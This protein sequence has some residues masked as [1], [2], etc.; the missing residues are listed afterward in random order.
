MA[1]TKYSIVPSHQLMENHIS[2]AVLDSAYGF[3]A[4]LTPTGATVLLSIGIDAI[5][6]ASVEAADTQTG[7]A[8]TDIN[9]LLLAKYKPGTT[10]TAHSFAASGNVT[11]TGFA[12]LLAVTVTTTTSSHDEVWLLTG[13]PGVDPSRWLVDEG[14]ITFTKLAYDPVSSPPIQAI[15]ADTLRVTGLHLESGLEATDPTLALATV[16]DRGSPGELRCF[17]LHLAPGAKPVWNYYQQEQNVGTTNLQLVPGRISSDSESWGLYKLYTLGA[18]TSL[19]YLP[20]KGRFG[21]PNATLFTVPSGATTMA[22]LVHQPRSSG[23]ATS[24]TDLFVAADGFIGYFPYNQRRPHEAIKL[25]T[26]PLVMGVTQ[27]HAVKCKD[28]AVLWGLNGAKQVFYTTAPLAERANPSAW[29]APIPLLSK[30]TAITAL[31][32]TAPNSISLFAV[33][34]LAGTTATGNSGS[35]LIQLS[36]NPSTGAWINSVHPLP[37][38]TDC[39]TLKT[40]TTRVLL[41]DS[42]NVPQPGASISAALSADCSLIINGAVKNVSTGET[43]SLKTDSGGYV[44]IIHAVSSLAT[45]R[46]TLTLPDGSPSTI[47]PTTAK[48]VASGT[49]PDAV[50]GVVAGLQVISAKI[51]DLPTAAAA[52]HSLSFNPSSNPSVTPGDIFSDLGDLVQWIN[53]VVEDVGN[54]VFDVVGEAIH[55]VVTVAETVFKAIINTVE[56]ALHAITALFN[57]IKADI[58]AVF[59]WLAFLFDWKD[60]IAV[61]DALKGVVRQSFTSFAKLE[62]RVKESGDKWFAHVKDSIL[63]GLSS[64]DMAKP[65]ED[66]SLQVV[67]AKNQRKPKTDLRSDTR[68]GWLKDRINTPPSSS[69]TPAAA[70]S[71]PTN[72]AL[73]ADNADPT[74]ALL[75]QIKT[76]IQH[77]L[78]TL[79]TAFDNLSKV[80]KGEMTA[81]KFFQDLL[82]SVEVLGLEALKDVFDALMSALQAITSKVLEALDM[83]IDIPIL[84]ALYKAATG[85]PLTLLDVLCLIIS[86]GVNLVYKIVTGGGNPHHALSSVTSD[87]IDKAIGG[88]LGDTLSRPLPGGANLS[89]AEKAHE[90]PFSDALQLFTGALLILQTHTL[91]VEGGAE[92]V[93]AFSVADMAFTADLAIRTLRL[94][95]EIVDNGE[96]MEDSRI[97]VIA[98]TVWSFSLLSVTAW[99]LS[100]ENEAVVTAVAN[101]DAMASLVWGIGHLIN[102]GHIT[103]EEGR[104]C[105]VGLTAEAFMEVLEPFQVGAAL[106]AQDEVALPVLVLRAGSALVAGGARFGLFA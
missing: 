28:R 57:L 22:S 32:G 72:S 59:R 42:N 17:L 70:T 1:P 54:F 14:A 95:L 38:T 43:V 23:A 39:V 16:A 69:K 12:I 97:Q 49:K 33:A 84:S 89:L 25:I 65:P 88:L 78:D 45:P 73:A 53:N 106:L 56:D 87:V 74:S 44:N 24:F 102:I 30:T 27:L 60:F 77:V 50:K 79:K 10:L 35:G 86:I 68:L 47:D 62:G 80:V 20:T 90:N 85:S 103:V 66:Q 76:L 96:Q 4:H 63:P 11:G 104:S 94:T 7:W 75:D 58:E 36:R 83:S 93:E 6:R 67:W 48:L 64:K 81:G 37:S 55:L 13:A 18:Q 52:A 82:T 19:T 98:E 5:F 105:P 41:V 34:P 26:S 51:P 21:P 100:T 31:A 15:T 3:S 9:P 71:G 91:A 8:V 61:K 101:A 99:G 92:M 40:Y 2:A 46:L 29:Q